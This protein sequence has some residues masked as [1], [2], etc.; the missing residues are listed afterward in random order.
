MFAS[1]MSGLSFGVAVG[2]GVGVGV[3]VGVIVGVGIG[4]GLGTGEV[5]AF[6]SK[7]PG[8]TAFGEVHGIVVAG[9]VSG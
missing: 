5:Q 7:L 4:V 9:L 3:G 2:D 1:V 6:P 8:F